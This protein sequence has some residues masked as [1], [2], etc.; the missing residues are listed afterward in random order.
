MALLAK[1][2]DEAGHGLYLYAATETLGNGTIRSTEMLL[3]TT[4]CPGKQS[5][6]VSLI[7]LH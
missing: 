1:V 4:C 5:I 7:I 6:P 2:Q 3:M